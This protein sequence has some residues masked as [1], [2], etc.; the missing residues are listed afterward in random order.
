ML[1][2]QKGVV[3]TSVR[4]LVEFLL[5]TGDITTGSS[6]SANPEAMLEG[7]RLHRKIQR[8]QKATYQSEVPLKMEWEEEGYNLALEGRADGIDYKE[9]DEN[10]IFYIDEIKCVY[11]DVAAI[12][13]AEPLHLAQ[14]KCYAYMYGHRHDLERID[15]QITYCHL[16]TEE[17]KRIFYSYE[18][19]EL[20]LWF[21]DLLDSYRMWAS[22]YVKAREKRNES[23]QQL[24]F[25]FSFR[26]EQKKMT[27]I[28]Y[29]AIEKKNHVFLQ[30]P[31]GVG[32]TISTLYP[33]LKELG[34]EKAENIFYLT[35]KT[36]TRT[37]A[38]DTIGLLKRQGLSL[39]A[40]TITAKEKICIQEEMNCNPESCERAKG[41]FNRINVALYAL[42]TSECESNRENLLLYAEKY[43][44]CPYELSFEAATWADC[45]IC[46]YNYVFNPHVNRKSLIAGNSRQNIYLID[47]AH[48]LLDR[49]RDMYSADISKSDF[50]LPKKYFKGKNSFLFKKVNNCVMALRKIEKQAQEGE[51]FNFHENADAMYFP[52][53]HLLGPLQ[54]Y[55]TDYDRFEEREELVEFY[56]KISHFYM[57]LDSLNSGYEI[58]GEKRGRDF[59]LRL[60]CVNP[61][62]KLKEYIENSRCSIFFSATLLPVQYYRQLLGGGHFEAYQ[63]TSPFSKENRLL[64]I[65]EDVTSRYTRRGEREYGKM[66]RY[67][68]LCLEKKAGNYMIF[69]PSYEM[70]SEVYAIAE[71]GNL[72]LVSEIIVQEPYM[73]EKNREEFL[74]RFREEREKPLIGFCVLGSI[75]S[76]GIDLTGKSL[77]GVCI[78]GTGLPQICNEREVIRAYFD[79]QQKKGYDYAYRYPGMNKVL[80]AAGRVIR[81]AED[82]GTILLMD[83]RFL[84]MKNQ[85]LLPEEWSSYYAVNRNNYGQLLENFWS[86]H[87]T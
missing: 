26:P 73:E 69:F 42:L 39:A 83:E 82:V 5:R 79:R 22:Y 84:E 47:E 37:V 56:F 41:H 43:Q 27:A 61:S 24:K 21:A 2:Y 62:D 85:R 45:I 38:Q 23:I 32:K 54:E 70:L 75:F 28:V 51:H 48:N 25:P 9:S 8:E 78:V 34:E 18:M 57:I 52:I 3:K 36:I 35:A 66:I 81:T 16:E 14:A 31:T 76:E 77:I 4:H 65:T 12:E 44:V 59:F 20:S 63:I 71:A 19:E 74:Q 29:Q 17:I 80:Q 13:E 33:A 46:D 68:E 86:G 7:G 30:A 10:R 67:L 50:K 64:S 1:S 6:V 58:Y 72:A 40:V 11:K 53:F 49:A 87:E 60:F 55:L 15:I